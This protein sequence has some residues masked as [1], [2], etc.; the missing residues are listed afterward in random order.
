MICYDVS[1]KKFM[2][3]TSCYN[4][5]LKEAFVMINKNAPLLPELAPKEVIEIRERLEQYGK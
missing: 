2:V 3:L 4:H 5:I 1:V